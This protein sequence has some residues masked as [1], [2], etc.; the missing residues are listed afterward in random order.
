MSKRLRVHPQTKWEA[1]SCVMS[2][3]PDRTQARFRAVSKDVMAMADKSI[4]AP[5]C[6][7]IIEKH[8]ASML[9][10]GFFEGITDSFI[11]LDTGEIVK[12]IMLVTSLNLY[13]ST[14]VSVWVYIHGRQYRV[15]SCFI[16]NFKFIMHRAILNDKILN[17]KK[18]IHLKQVME[19]LMTDANYTER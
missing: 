11:Q 18:D 4:S 16:K 2:Y 6:A 13:D 3:L 17:K 15:T 19:S 10:D 7:P 1:L 5:F 12:D 14:R 8:Y 9:T